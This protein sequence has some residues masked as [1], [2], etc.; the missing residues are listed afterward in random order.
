MRWEGC[1]VSCKSLMFRRS[2]NALLLCSIF[3]TIAIV[4]KTDAVVFSQDSLWMIVHNLNIKSYLCFSLRVISSLICP[5][6]RTQVLFA[7]LF[8]L[9]SQFYSYSPQSQITAG[10]TPLPL[11]LCNLY[12]TS[13]RA[14]WL[15]VFLA[16]W[17][18]WPVHLFFSSS[19]LCPCLA[20]IVIARIDGLAVGPIDPQ[21]HTA[22]YWQMAL[23]W[24][25]S[26][27]PSSSPFALYP[28]F[29]ICHS[30]HCN[31]QSPLFSLNFFEFIRL[32]VYLFSCPSP[33]S[34]SVAAIVHQ[35]SRDQRWG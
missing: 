5:L 2:G 30:P 16:Y 20:W 27:L 19:L 28:P 22:G 4:D 12:W 29:L 18:L 3:Q 21:G 32:A 24:P 31:F 33:C 7:S 34:D 6:H 10:F 9:Q 23:Q 15:P 25:L 11:F 35:C 8:L 1:S 13:V 26:L 17:P 14:D